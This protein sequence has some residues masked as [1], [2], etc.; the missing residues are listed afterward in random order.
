MKPKKYSTLRVM[1]VVICGSA[2][3]T[4]NGCADKEEVG[5]YN[6]STRIEAQYVG[7]GI[8]AMYVVVED[9]TKDA[10][11]A[12]LTRKQ[13]QTDVELKLRQEGIRIRSTPVDAF[14]YVNVN[15]LKILDGSMLAHSIAV[16]LKQG[17]SLK[18]NPKILILATTWSKKMTGYAGERVFVSRMRQNVSDLIDIFLNDYL[19]ANPK[20]P[21]VW[22]RAANELREKAAKEKDE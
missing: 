17:V 14:L 6:A 5:D 15:I 22:E 20:E 8:D 9:L 10:I 12:G 4:I 3:Y 19:A 16:E 2:L 13:I 11:E 18:R 21:D 1:L 7:T